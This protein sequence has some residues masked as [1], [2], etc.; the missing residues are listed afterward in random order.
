MKKERKNSFLR[1]ITIIFAFVFVLILPSCSGFNKFVD[2]GDSSKANYYTVTWK[3]GD[4]STLL[5]QKVRP[6]VVPE[7]TGTEIP[8]KTS[9]KNSYV[10]DETWNPEPSPI[11][12]NTV[13]YPNFVIETDLEFLITWRNDDGT[14]LDTESYAYG[15]MP[16]FK[17]GTPFKESTR[18]YSYRF[19][20][21][22]PRIIRVTEDQ[23]YVAQYANINRY[24]ITWRVENTIVHTSYVDEGGMPVYDKKV[25][26]EFG[27]D[28]DQIDYPSQPSTSKWNYEFVGWSPAFRPATAN[29]SYSAIFVANKNLFDITFKN[30]STILQSN[31][32]EYGEKAVYA[33]KEPTKMA[34]AG[35]FYEFS[36]WDP[37][38]NTP[39]TKDTVFE[40]KFNSVTKYEVKYNIGDSVVTKYFKKGEI[41][42]YYP[43]NQ[44]EVP[45]KSS[46]ASN[47]VNTFYNWDP[48]FKAMGENAATYKA[49][50]GTDSTTSYVQS[51]SGAISSWQTLI[52]N[53]NVIVEDGTLIDTD[54]TTNNVVNK[55]ETLLIV[56][57]PEIKKILPGALAPKA[58][59]YPG[60]IK[61]LLPHTFTSITKGIFN[62]IS[63]GQIM[64]PKSVIKIE[65][66]AFPMGLKSI[67]YKGSA[68]DWGKITI[69]DA[70][71]ANMTPTYDQ[72]NLVTF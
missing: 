54:F 39:V 70:F 48:A 33:S 60:T 11:R 50:F 44:S 1:F 12:Q 9:S 2:S 18:N 13:F 20:N 65:T 68:T 49:V 22:E 21:W 23:E 61:L 28:T 38:I 17:G 24:T 56:L 26:D 43:S 29:A 63:G 32:I 8:T 34:G 52:S 64:I 46:S 67:S 4:G 55:D 3:N 19:A 59:G 35:S 58:I 37:D 47:I 69:N 5:E 53:G 25:K 72:M 15:T 57:N 31:K 42:Y 41:P 71:A 40:A 27:K 51:S 30:G 7:Y 36:G 16:D 66:S 45:K 14:I 10:F 62:N 6:G